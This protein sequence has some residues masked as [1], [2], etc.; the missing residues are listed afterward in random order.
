MEETVAATDIEWVPIVSVAAPTLT[1]VG[2]KTEVIRDRPP[3][4]ISSA[5]AQRR[6]T[7]RGGALYDPGFAYLTE[8]KYWCICGWRLEIS[9]PPAR[10]R[11]LRIL[12]LIGNRRLGN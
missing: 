8:L 11:R 4:E 1:E 3:K 5:V 2:E 9:R 7:A 12:G 10:L 6:D